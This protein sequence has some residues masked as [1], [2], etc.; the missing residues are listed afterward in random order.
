MRK[1]IAVLATVMVIF[2]IFIFPASATGSAVLTLK[3]SNSNVN[4][5]DTVTITGNMNATDMEGAFDLKVIYNPA[6]LEYKSAEGISP[7]IKAG[8]M[9]VVP[10]SGSIQL[11]Y[12]DGDGG[13]TGIKSADAFKVVF[14]VI[15]GNVGDSIYVDTQVKKIGDANFTAMSSSVVKTSMKIVPPLSKNVFLS[16]LTVGDSTLTPAFDKNVISYNTSVP[17]SVEKLVINATAEDNA[18]KV[19]VNSPTLT[20]G[21][22]TAATVT[23][24]APNGSKNTYTIQV[25]R[26]QDPNYQPAGNN[27]LTSITVDPGILSP[28]FKSDVTSYVVWLPYETDKIIITGKP[29]DTKSSVTVDGGSN[30]T[31][32]AD[33]AV[34]VICTAENG[35]TKTYSVIVKRAAG[36]TGA[37]I[38]KTEETDMEKVMQN[39]AAAGKNGAVQTVSV[40]LNAT[41]T[42]KF[43]TL[44]F[45]TLAENKSAL[46]N[47]KFNGA[48]IT[49]K[50]QD[51]QK[52]DTEQLYDFA[53]TKGS[54]YKEIM[55]KATGDDKNMF[56]YSFAYHGNLPG[57]ATFDI[58]TDFN[59][60]DVVNVYQYDPANQTYTLI[61]EQIK[62]G[63]G[64]VVSYV[65]NTCSDYLITTKVIANAATSVAMSKQTKVVANSKQSVMIIVVVA[66]AMLAI[67]IA[68]G[69]LIPVI[70]KKRN[71]TF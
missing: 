24:T 16:S 32:G 20:P 23:V 12:L 19:T 1:P 17:F 35:K 58:N 49:F 59:P 41:K 6:Q 64:S 25:A 33:N 63:A 55:V 13:L 31:A 68:I 22:T 7:A 60:G 26:A 14:K 21:G 69:F 40:E 39:L 47:I 9:D 27:N 53:F 38:A 29:E 5:G 28:V 65:N 48:Q 11:L 51:V 37:D 71:R 61:A 66:I 8:E 18:S 45:N 70:F 3:T 57:Y 46:L 43:N 52:L 62:V 30:L 36:S 56:T 10:S 44:I 15:G 4:V 67:G 34:S 42:G 2:T 54:D 50:S